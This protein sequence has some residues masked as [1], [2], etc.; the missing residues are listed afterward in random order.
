MDEA[1]GDNA[2][3]REEV[4]SLLLAHDASKSFM[5]R[6]ALEMSANLTARY[7][8]LAEVPGTNIGPYKLLQQIGEGGMGTVFMAE[9]TEPLQRTVALKVIKPGMDTRQ[10][11][12]RFEAERQA[13][14]MM[15]HPN[16]AKVL[17]AG[18][19]ESGR[20]YFVM[21]LV[22]GVPITQY[23]DDKHLP[24]RARL[25]LFVQVCQGVQ[26]AH[27]KGIIHRD[28]KPNNVLVAEYDDHA[29]PKVIDF[30]VAK[31][32]AQKLTERTLFT[33]FGQVLGTMEYMSPEQA[34]LNQLDVD[35]RS[36][37]YSLG[38][39][40]YELLAG[41]TPFT[42]ERLKEAAFDEMLR[43]IREED[44]PKP[45][46]R[47]SSSDALPAI[48]ASRGLEPLKLNRL[49]QGDLDWIVMKALEKDRNAR[50]A[51][52][53]ELAADLAHWQRDEPISV[54]APGLAALL[55]VWLRHN[56]GSSSWAV[57]IGVIWGLLGGPVVWLV[58]LN[59]L[60]LS[61]GVRRALYFAGVALISALGPA[62][63]WL[64]R[65]KNA[66]AD[67]AAGT[68][69]GTLAAVITYTL[70]WG[71]VAVSIAGIPHGIWLGMAT[72]LG[73]KWSIAVI[74]T[75]AAGMLLRRYGQVSSMIGP[76]AELIVPANLAVVFACSALFRLVT[77]GLGE[78]FWHPIM[79]PLL[80]LAAISALARWPWYVRVVLH[81]AWV[82][83]LCKFL[84]L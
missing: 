31:A 40:L 39:L 3:L 81:A 50:Y 27:E 15:D 57:A 44:P 35:T 28:I 66:T 82:A 78:R 59:P 63:V 70:T 76:Y 33:E 14:A 42:R 54:R 74:E 38:V 20:P 47:L 25:E 71:W 10:V 23:C 62:I 48:A 5:E 53:N 83:S 37:I 7:Q 72:A 13:V 18:T 26:H 64:V 84:T 30:G 24:V 46:T 52:A 69:T 49:V 21:E 29:V 75:L 4:Q 51:A 68:I 45:S 19:T 12:A 61:I 77:V 60:E 73:F 1:C 36:D 34:K 55:R 79:V 8:S 11:I 17:D 67:L 2:E 6:P 32:T 22:K 58:M 65:P 43:I 41:S 9:Q 16:I 56:F 80:A